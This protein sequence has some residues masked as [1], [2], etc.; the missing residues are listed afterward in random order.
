MDYQDRVIGDS[1]LQ[2]IVAPMELDMVAFFSLLQEDVIK[3]IAQAKRE[4]L[5]PE[6]IQ[7]RIEELF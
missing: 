7:K 5:T 6:E 3:I 4:H 2:H 1:E